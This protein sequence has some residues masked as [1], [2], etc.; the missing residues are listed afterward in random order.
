MLY[1]AA[2]ATLTSH[3]LRGV[4]GDE[5]VPLDVESGFSTSKEL[6]RLGMT[7]QT[8]Y[9]DFKK[10][11]YQHLIQMKKEDEQMKKIGFS[12]WGTNWLGLSGGNVT[13]QNKDT[14]KCCNQPINN[15]PVL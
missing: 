15:I 8:F 6:G 9:A 4:R 12:N 14:A 13:Q 11:E 2:A 1:R 3:V 5:E 10:P 7:S